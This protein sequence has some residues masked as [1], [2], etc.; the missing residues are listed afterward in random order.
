ML[1]ATFSVEGVKNHLWWV[2]DWHATRACMLAQATSMPDFE[3]A[4]N[5]HEYVRMSLRCKTSHGLALES[6]PA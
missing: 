3:G 5:S 4:S 1:D 6:P 2:M